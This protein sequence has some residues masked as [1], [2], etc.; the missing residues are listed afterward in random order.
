MGG[1]S[2]KI[3]DPEEVAEISAETGFSAKQIHRLYNR[4]TTLDRSKAGYLKR[5]DFLLIP[6]LAINPLGDRI[7]NEFFK[8]GEELN[9]REFMQKVARFRKP[10]SSGVTEYNNREAKLRFLFGM[11]DLDV[12]NRISRSELLS[13]LQMMVGASVTMEQINR[14]GERTMAEADVDGDGYITYDEFKAAVES[15]DIENKMSIHFL[16]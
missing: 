4:Y 1:G 8:G 10:N 15:V 13:V 5:Q 3:L 11:Y 14:I 6:E 2:S 9:F 12:D 7:I 16:D